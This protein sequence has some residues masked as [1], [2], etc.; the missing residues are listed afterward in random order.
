MSYHDRRGSGPA[1]V[2]YARPA[3]P[4][5]MRG[6]PAAAAP[7]PPAPMQPAAPPP[8]L[9]VDREKV[10]LSQCWLLKPFSVQAMQ[11]WTDSTAVPCQTCPLL[12]R[13]FPKVSRDRHFV[14]LLLLSLFVYNSGGGALQCLCWLPAAPPH[15]LRTCVSPVCRLY[16]ATDNLHGLSLSTTA[17]AAFAAECVCANYVCTPALQH[18]A[19]HHLEE[20]AERGK[21]P[22]EEVQV[23]TWMDATLRELTELIQEVQPAARRQQARLEFALI[24]PDRRGRNV[25]REARPW[26]LC[27]IWPRHSL[28][29]ACFWQEAMEAA[30]P[31]FPM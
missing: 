28:K 13:V 24:Y 9:V 31:F 5:P 14:R 30:H 2:D 10:T 20:F 4:G 26:P 19:H 25:L 17:Y 18:G 12:L 8:R 11:A 1:A 16:V 15:T 6:G 27:T 23:Y 21:E 29:Y 22:K 3:P 7:L